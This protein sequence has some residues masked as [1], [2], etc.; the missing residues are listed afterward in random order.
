MPMLAI[1]YELYADATRDAEIIYRNGIRHP[2]VT[3]PVP[4]SVLA[5]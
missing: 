3:P 5:A 4:L 1:A 2:G